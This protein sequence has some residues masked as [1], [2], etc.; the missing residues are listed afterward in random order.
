MIQMI[1]MIQCVVECTTIGHQISVTQNVGQ[2]RLW[3][4]AQTIVDR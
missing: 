4:L 3:F 1:Q 2:K